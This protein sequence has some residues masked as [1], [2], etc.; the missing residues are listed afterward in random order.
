M[1]TIL[2]LLVAGQA[3]GVDIPNGSVTVFCYQKGQY[4]LLKV[5]TLTTSILHPEWQEL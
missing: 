4:R 1:L 3:K 5:G 2:H